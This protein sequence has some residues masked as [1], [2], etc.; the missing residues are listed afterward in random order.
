MADVT[1]PEVAEVVVVEGWRD[2]AAVD[3]A[4]KADVVV[5]GGMAVSRELIGFLRK[6][7]AERG[8]IILTDPDAMGERIRKRI[9]DRVPGCKHAFIPPEEATDGSDIGI[10]HASPSAIDR[11]LARVR[12]EVPAK[13]WRITWSDMMEAGLVGAPGASVRRAKVARDLGVGYGNAKSFW[14][15]LNVLGVDPEEFRAAVRSA[16][17]V[18]SH[19]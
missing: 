15:R 18:R 5:T 11:A 8:V 13:A 14:K 4:V 12:T 7:V 1:K 9:A 19:D 6:V 10:E 3:R 16:G 17:G 2:K